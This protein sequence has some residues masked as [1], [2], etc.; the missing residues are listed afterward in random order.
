MSLKITTILLSIILVFSCSETSSQKEKKAPHQKGVMELIDDHN[1][2]MIEDQYRMKVNSKVVEIYLENIEFDDMYKKWMNHFQF[3]IN[4]NY[5][6]QTA[7]LIKTEKEK[8]RKFKMKAAEILAKTDSTELA[9]LKRFK[10]I[11]NM[12]DTMEIHIIEAEESL[13]KRR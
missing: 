4:E 12:I 11:Q 6:T 2:E 5:R 7:E 10:T 13:N 8:L 3:K 1:L 9:I